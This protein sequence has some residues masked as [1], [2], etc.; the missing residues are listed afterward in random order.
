M[1]YGDRGAGDVIPP[2]AT[3]LF[4]IVVMDVE[5]VPRYAR[6]KKRHFVRHKNPQKLDDTYIIPFLFLSLNPESVFKF[7]QRPQNA[8]HFSF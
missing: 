7:I 5:Q 8:S 3:L 4:D 2:D 1:A 6:F